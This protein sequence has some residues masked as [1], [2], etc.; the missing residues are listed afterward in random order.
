MSG[1]TCA[2][3]AEKVSVDTF[4]P[5][6][7][8][9]EKGDR[10]HVLLIDGNDQ[11]VVESHHNPFIAFR[12]NMMWWQFAQARGMSDERAMAL[13]QSVDD[14]IV[15]IGGVGFTRTPM[16]FQSA[17]SDRLSFESPGGVWVKDETHNVGGSQKARHLMSILLHLLVAE[18]L[19]IAPWA[20]AAARPTLAISSCGNAAIAASTLAA[21][22]K[23]PIDVFIPEW[24]GGVVVETLT[25]LGARINRCARQSQ[26]PPGDPTV[27]RFREAV[28]TGSIPFS[29][30]GPENALC[31]DGGRTIGWEM[32]QQFAQENIAALD[33]VF[34]QV[35]GGAFAASVSR[36]L[37]EAGI[38]A[39]LV[40][41]QTEGCAPLSRA[42]NTAQSD[43][44][45]A[46]H[47]TKHMWAWENEPVSL[48]DGILDDE[49]YDWVADIAQIQR[50]SGRVV[51]A[52]EL[53]VVEA[54]SIAPQT[55]SIDASPTGTAGVA[56]LL[57]IRAE[58]SSTAR[59]AV[60]LSGIRR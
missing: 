47:W 2:T 18:E 24:A 41:V 21:A 42:W 52:S 10:H 19:G 1:F 36:G 58:L 28:N 9:N 16:L 48:A 15:K 37:S 20:D 43:A 44:N 3:C 11:H 54:S 17:L 23:W 33:A 32:A 59:V 13:V 39:S 31:L 34:V 40:A 8:P 45:P 25:A 35:G 46:Q 49:T 14:E 30:Q 50:T 56:G 6:R 22:A 12:R 55:T 7:C 5:W 51:V 27:L 26:D 60:V 57:S 53:Q 4:A 38:N 29:V